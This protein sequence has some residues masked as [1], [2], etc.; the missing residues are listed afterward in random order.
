MPSRRKSTDAPPRPGG[1]GLIG[2]PSSGKTAYMVSLCLK[3]RNDPRWTFT[4]AEAA[5]NEYVQKLKQETDGS[6]KLWENTQKD[7]PHRDYS[8]FAA[9]R[10]G[11]DAGE[12]ATSILPR[13]W[14]AGFQKAVHVPEL[15]GELIERASLDQSMAST[16]DADRVSRLLDYL[17]ACSGI[18]CL[19]DP[20]VDLNALD[21]QIGNVD[22]VIGKVL[23]KRQKNGI[24]DPLHL[25]FALTK[26]DKL[27]KDPDRANIRLPA[28]QSKRLKWLVANNRRGPDDGITEAGLEISYSLKNAEA[29]RPADREHDACVVWDL[30]GS[31]LRSVYETCARYAQDP[32]ITIEPFLIS[33]WGHPLQKGKVGGLEGELFPRLDEINPR[34]HF[35]PMVSVLDR[36]YKLHAARARKRRS[37]ALAG[38]WLA[39]ILFGPAAGYL[40]GSAASWRA[41]AGDAGTSRVA[42]K[43]AE[44]HPW[45]QW[46]LARNPQRIGALAKASLQRADTLFRESGNLTP[47]AVLA[48]RTARDWSTPEG[49]S[50]VTE[51]LDS[52]VRQTAESLRASG[53]VGE[54]EVL[55][56]LFGLRGGLDP[57][58]VVVGEMLA[59]IETL[60]QGQAEDQLTTE[61]KAELLAICQEIAANAWRHDVAGIIPMPTALKTAARG[62][63]ASLLLA[64]ARAELAT[65]GESGDNWPQIV[66]TCSEARDATFAA[67]MRELLRSYEQDVG[68]PLAQLEV[69]AWRKRRL[70]QTPL[71]E[72]EA[73]PDVVK[74]DLIKLRQLVQEVPYALPE[75]QACLDEYILGLRSDLRERL[76]QS[77]PVRSVDSSVIEILRV[78]EALAGGAQSSEAVDA[79][80]ALQN[81]AV[82]LESDV[83]KLPMQLYQ[84]AREF[85]G[86]MDANVAFPLRD[87][88]A[89]RF[90]T[91]FGRCMVAL[92]ELVAARALQYLEAHQAWQPEQLFAWKETVEGA[93]GTAAQPLL[94]CIMLYREWRSIAVKAGSGATP[95]R[96]PRSFDAALSA[97]ALT[98]EDIRSALAAVGSR[99]ASDAD[100]PERAL[101]FASALRKRRRENAALAEP[102]ANIE[103][104]FR[105]ALVDASPSWPSVARATLL[106]EY[107]AQ[108]GGET[109]QDRE[110]HWWFIDRCLQPT[111]HSFVSGHV[112]QAA[113]GLRSEASAEKNA[114]LKPHLASLRAKLSA[115][116]RV[117]LAPYARVDEA[118]RAMDANTI[119]GAI[120]A[121]AGHL[122]FLRQRGQDYAFLPESAT[123]RGFY[124]AKSE[125]SVQEIRAALPACTPPVIQFNLTGSAEDEYELTA[126][127]M[128]A[129]YSNILEA[130]QSKAAF[131]MN[132]RQAMQMAAALAPEGR[133]PTSQEWM[134]VYLGL[135][136]EQEAR[137]RRDARLQS[138]AGLEE[139]GDRTASGVLGLLGNL[140]EWVID[141]TG[142]PGLIGY[143]YRE[144]SHEKRPVTQIV[145]E[146]DLVRGDGRQLGQNHLRC[147]LRVCFSAVPRA[148]ENIFQ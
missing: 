90:A 127:G 129:N 19:I 107:V 54:V 60:S 33:S 56:T 77:R 73:Q 42:L 81:F 138:Q 68:I 141:D 132:S 45:V 43:L 91:D 125:A 94:E 100:A 106:R 26:C 131:G 35:D 88:D 28:S 121:A 84:Q 17:A 66:A 74:T 126:T 39:G 2:T 113:E 70:G 12:R 24:R 63:R 136:D 146:R 118:A 101:A 41:E 44:R 99:L 95:S 18:I 29:M 78:A 108:L 34:R 30:M 27:E 110:Q 9:T 135:E 20:T 148:L 89:W 71:K 38:L 50:A 58:P 32:R 137:R 142:Q 122:T 87:G 96:L 145:L 21:M 140:R 119:Q 55:S 46:D 124:F 49:Q 116:E 36:T 133:L 15:P 65:A 31:N 117:S 134:H 115:G 103:R 13:K 93:A 62:P 128:N 80:A 69:A 8:L 92:D 120:E 72:L 111:T 75:V 61:C 104:G 98:R 40:L 64:K 83:R 11:L 10:R 48:A 143:S 109:P 112:K 53:P 76:L 86:Q 7:L 102:L 114:R 139:R 22:G 144:T 123:L 37:I 47:D 14:S 97:T 59:S 5:F 105:D 82:A 3:I 147:G 51:W 6:R 25:S 1:F 23:E 79:L 85:G 130:D 4:I 16:V 67:G 57:N 52:R